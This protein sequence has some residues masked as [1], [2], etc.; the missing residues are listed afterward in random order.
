MQLDFV[1]NKGIMQMVLSKVKEYRERK[2]M[3]QEAL[4]RYTKRSQSE[5]S[6]I[7]N[8]KLE[9]GVGTAMRIAKVLGATVEELFFED[10]GSQQ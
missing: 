2:G 7:E 10:E 9:P 8:G 1:T 6:A 5:I 3:K 4:A